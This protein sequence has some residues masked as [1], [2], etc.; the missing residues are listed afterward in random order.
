MTN[1]VEAETPPTARYGWLLAVPLTVG[2]LLLGLWLFAGLLA[3]GYY[4]SFVFATAWFVIAAIVLSRVRSRMPFLDKAIRFTYLGTV[5]VLVAVFALTTFRSDTVTE[6]VVAPAAGNTEIA[7]GTFSGVA[8]KAVGKAMVV[9]L[10]SGGQKLTFTE[11]ETDN[12]PDLR[13]LLV[14]GDVRGDSDVSDFRDLGPL[15]GNRGN[16]QYDVP[17]DVDVQR[18]ATVVIWCRAFSISFAKATL[19]TA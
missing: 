17:A 14:A 2:F 19:A 9:K 8:H 13:V 7:S 4:A 10:A 15:K 11:F 18:Y 5:A 6:Q 3:P 1:D 16:Q 12:G